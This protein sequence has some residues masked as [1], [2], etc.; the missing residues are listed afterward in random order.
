M[1]LDYTVELEQ[2]VRRQHVLSLRTN[3]PNLT[4]LFSDSVFYA[5]G[6]RTFWLLAARGL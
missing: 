6:L 1:R 2:T 4:E 3:K 5:H